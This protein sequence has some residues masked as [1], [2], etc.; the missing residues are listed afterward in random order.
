MSKQKAPKEKTFSARV[1]VSLKPTVNDPEG[2]TI[3]GAIG[4]L[5]FEGV[6]RVRAGKYFQLQVVA[7]TKK[8]AE[9]LV[10]HVCARLLANPV[11]ETYSYD[12]EPA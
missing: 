6:Q 1:Y 8:T 12:V 3:A 2:I 4:S 5:G 7:P 10:D 9:K 11:I